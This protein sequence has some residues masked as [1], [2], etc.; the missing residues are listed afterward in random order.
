MRTFRVLLIFTAVIF[1]LF[2]RSISHAFASEYF[3]TSYYVTY[4]VLEDGNT[5]TSMKVTLTNKTSDY[6]A[7]SYK[8]QVGFEHI[9]NLSVRD[10]DGLL[11]PKMT[12]V[13]GGTIIE[14]EFNKRVVGDGNSLTYTISFDTPDIAKKDGEIWEINIPGLEDANSFSNFTAEVKVPSSFGTPAYIKPRQPT[15]QT[16]FTKEQLGKSGIS[17]SYGDKQVYG[18]NLFYHLKNSNLFPVRTEIAIPPNTNYQDVYIEYMNPKP[19][20]V[21]IDGDGNWLASYSLAPSEKMT[22]QTRGT[23][24][25]HLMPK[26]EPLSS[27]QIKAYLTEQPYWEISRSEIKKLANELKT[28]KAIYEY[29]VKNLTYDFSRVEENKVR[30]GGIGTLQ[31]KNSAVCLE[32]TDLFITLARA[33]GI[34]AREVDGY[35]NTENSRQRPLSLVKDILHAWPEYYD[36]NTQRWIMVDPTWGNT[37]GG[38]D[39]FD[40][41][42]FDHFAFV[43]RGLDSEYPVPAGGYKYKEDENLKDVNVSFPRFFTP[44]QTTISIDFD[45]KPHYSLL[46]IKATFVMNNTGAGVV[47]TQKLNILSN[48]LTP[49][50][51][52]YE[53]TDIPPFGHIDVPVTYQP[54]PFLTNGEFPLT[55]TI[56]GIT[57][58]DTLRVQPILFSIYSLVGGLTIAVLTILIFIITKKSRRIPVLRS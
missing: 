2:S 40:V 13:E 33:A 20:N 58:T 12:K 16:I 10:P 35:A 41:L 46:P 30:L 22:V 9:E 25:V 51:Q 52:S 6:F 50:I 15:N 37:T 55:I 1:L 23:A 45:S 8:V 49:K 3:S 26:K 17:I 44:P 56:A 14:A 19:T 27:K 48:N 31:Q 4:S 18:F 32:F 38:V 53:I 36:V 21:T 5:H 54:V 42:D 43:I 57:L 47:T 11:D 7:S 39:Y 28:A 24:V 34:P 29:L